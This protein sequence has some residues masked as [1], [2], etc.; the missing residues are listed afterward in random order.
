MVTCSTSAGYAYTARDR[1]LNSPPVWF[2][3]AIFDAVQYDGRVRSHQLWK[4]I[5]DHLKLGPP[6]RKAKKK[7]RKA[8]KL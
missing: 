2:K 5:A 1:F 3:A 4:S 8:K 6:E 7:A